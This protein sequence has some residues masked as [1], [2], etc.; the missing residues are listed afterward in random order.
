M[1][2]G[3]PIDNVRAYILDEEM[4]PLPIGVPGELMISSLQVARGYL[5]RPEENEKAFI[6]NPYGQGDHARLYRTGD[7]FW[8]VCKNESWL[9]KVS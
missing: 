6:S 5:K 4:Q 3:R 2:I 7:W 8:Q 9:T 1:P